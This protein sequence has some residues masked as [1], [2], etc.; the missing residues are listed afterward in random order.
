MGDLM[1]KAL[2]DVLITIALVSNSFGVDIL[3]Y[4]S[5]DRFLNSPGGSVKVSRWAVE[6][7][8]EKL[9]FARQKEGYCYFAVAETLFSPKLSGTHISWAKNGVLTTVVVLH[10][11]APA[12]RYK[13]C[14]LYKLADRA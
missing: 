11:R 10:I 5:E 14:R 9:N 1:F 8:L 3:K 13:S 12:W 2:D 7:R 6:K 4:F